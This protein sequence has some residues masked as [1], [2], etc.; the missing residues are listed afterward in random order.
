MTLPANDFNEKYAA[1]DGKGIGESITSPTASQWD[2]I[3]NAAMK[4]ISGTAYPTGG[5][6]TGVYLP[7]S[8]IS[9]T[10]TI[11][12]GGIYVEGD[13]S[14][15]QLSTGT[16]SSGNST[17]I[18]TITQG[19]TTTTVTTD[20]GAN[21]TTVHSASSTLTLAGVPSNLNNSPA[22]PATMLYV[23]GNI[24]N[25][26][27]TGTG[28]SGPGQGV[29]AIQDGAA[30]TVTAKSNITITGDI[31]YKT[32]PVTL[33][34]NQT[35]SGTSPA[36]CNGDPADTLIPG[37]NKGQALGIFTATGNID[38]NNQQ[39]NGNLEVD[40]SMATIS[41]GG[42]GGLTNTGSA[43]NTLNI[44]G[45]RIQNTI[46]NINTTTRNIFFDRRYAPGSGLRRPGFRPRP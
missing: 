18:Y 13:A 24:G 27:G 29:A 44:V 41:T 11:T 2:T 7:Y 23:D 1:I 34:Q 10:N 16:D 20:I 22:T 46:Q 30:V 39:S 40:A 33:T 9:G 15:V 37:A 36:C 8:S 4:N 42:S 32:E 38:L 14:S 43:I 45:G 35:V 25:S 5:T 3:L 6:T 31:L 28:L 26:S 12:G 21:T 17:Q 19:A